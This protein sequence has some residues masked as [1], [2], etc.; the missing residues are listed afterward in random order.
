MTDLSVVVPV[1][2]EGEV[3]EALILALER[4]PGRPGARGD[5][6][7]RRVVGRTRRRSSSGCRARAVAR[8]PTERAERRSRHL[9]P[10]R[11]ASGA[12]GHGSSSPTPTASSSSPMCIGSG[13]GVT[14]AISC[15]ASGR[16]ARI[17]LHRLVLTRIVRVDDVAPLRPPIQ[18]VNTPFRLLRREVWDDLR[19]YRAGRDAR[20]QH[21]RHLG[22]SLRGW[23]LV[24]IPVTHLPERAGP[25]D[26][27]LAAARPIQPPRARAAAAVSRAARARGPRQPRWQRDES[28]TRPRRSARLGVGSQARPAIASRQPLPRRGARPCRCGARAVRAR[29]CG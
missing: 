2:N 11:A 8:C 28:S 18:D 17:P 5:R 23:T 6:R 10:A 7:R 25:C 27:A 19:P 4:E 12:R 13:S 21:L 29:R 22:A 16:G 20:A 3:V 1:F 9:R 14:T 24:E 15:S 26:A